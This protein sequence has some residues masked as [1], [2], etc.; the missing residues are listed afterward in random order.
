[1]SID[2]ILF[3]KGDQL[4]TLKEWQAALDAAEAD[5]VLDEISDLREH[6]GYF[7]LTFKGEPSGFEWYFTTVEEMFPDGPPDWLGG[8]D[9]AV[10]LVTFGDMRE[11]YCAMTAGAILGKISDAVVWEG[12]SPDA[13]LRDAEEAK[14]YLN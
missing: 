4:P 2:N 13:W 3:L 10:D 7:P 6:S 5:I 8:R 12:I 11:F 14:Q 9:H 1:M